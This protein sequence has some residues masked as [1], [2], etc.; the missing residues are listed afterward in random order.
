MHATL[1]TQHIWAAFLSSCVSETV[2]VK[3]LP[4][5]QVSASVCQSHPLIFLSKASLTFNALQVDLLGR[6]GCVLC[7]FE[8]VLHEAGA[9]VPSVTIG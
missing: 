8:A 2:V 6:G 1:V 4:M 5:Y 7:F 9:G 3:H